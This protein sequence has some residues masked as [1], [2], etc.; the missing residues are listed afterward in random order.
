MVKV[1]VMVGP[2]KLTHKK[3]DVVEEKED[4]G[5]GSTGEKNSEQHSGDDT[6]EEFYTEENAFQA[7]DKKHTE[8][9]KY[10]Y[11]IQENVKRKP[12]LKMI[13]E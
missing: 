5:S 1:M 7:K 6:S 10:K 8:K 2:K 13:K 3:E 12:P 9:D 11:K 4:A